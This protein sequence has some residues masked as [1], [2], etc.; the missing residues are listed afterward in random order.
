MELNCVEQDVAGRIKAHYQDRRRMIIGRVANLTAPHAGR[1]NCQYRD[2]CWSRL[3]VR[4]VFQHAV[5]DAARRGADRQPDAAAVLD[6]DE[7]ALR[8][9]RPEGTGVE[10]LDAE[11]NMT[12]EYKARI[13]L[14]VRVHV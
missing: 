1:V 8:P 7:A 13:R 6:R 11:T 3:P 2:K 9:R 10:V 14:R 5:V 4:R 12:R